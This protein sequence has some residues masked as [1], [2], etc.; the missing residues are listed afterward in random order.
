MCRASCHVT[1]T[2]L[3]AFTLAGDG[4]VKFWDLR[5]LRR[6]VNQLVAAGGAA[7]AAATSHEDLFAGSTACPLG[8]N[9]S[10]DHGITG[11][12]TSEHGDRLLVSSHANVHYMY[13]TATLD[14]T[15]V[16]G[17]SQRLPAFYCNQLQCVMGGAC[18]SDCSDC[19]IHSLY[20][21]H[22]LGLEFPFFYHFL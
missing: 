3:V 13:H 11:M 20:T 14:K 7:A 19:H 16:A 9:A 5:Q 4:T 10:K 15:P 17:M 22:Q 6:P 1:M 12:A 2:P 18:T 21:F 8:P